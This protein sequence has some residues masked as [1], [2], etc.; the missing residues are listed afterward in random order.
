MTS[1]KSNIEELGEVVTQIISFKSGETKT[2]K[3]IKTN[4]MSQSQFTRFDT[5]DGKRYMIND[6]E[7]NWIETLKQWNTATYVLKK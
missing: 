7:V 6:K 3:N 2:I 5:T 1:L 4:S